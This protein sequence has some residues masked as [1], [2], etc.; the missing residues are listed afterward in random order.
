MTRFLICFLALGG[1]VA[2]AATNIERFNSH[3]FVF[4]AVAPGNPYDA[5][6]AG[7]FSGPGGA[8]MRVP[9]F[10]DGDGR[11]IIRFAPNREGEWQLRTVSSL[12]AL[13]GKT[14]NGIRCEP[15]RS[16]ENHGGLRVDPAHPYHFVYEDGTRYF[17]LGYEA[18]WLWAADMQDPDRR[19]MRK[20]IDQMA[21]RGFNH[22]MVN[23]YAYDTG[24][25]KGR[26]HQWDWGPAPVFPW[27]GTNE[28]PDHSRFNPQYFRIY[29]GMMSAL[30]GKG[31]VAHIMLKVY[32]KQVNWPKPYSRDEERYF[33]Y[34]TARYQ[35]YSN[36]V[37]DFSKEAH[38]ERDLS[39][40]A[41]LIELVRSTDAYHRLLTAHDDDVFYWTPELNRVLDFRTDQQHTFWPEMIAFDRALRRYP[42]LNSEFGYERPVDRFPTYRVEH[43][44]EEQLRR[45]WL[46]YLAGG[47]GVYYYHNTAWDVVKPDPEPPGMK[48]FQ[49]LKETLAALPYWQME[50]HNELAVGGPCLAL[51]GE[52]YAV[53][54]GKDPV[55]I[56]LTGMQAPEKARAEWVDTWT[57]KTEKAALQP[58]PVQR[59]L[60]KPEAFGD[61]P[62]L[63]VIR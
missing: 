33:R 38:N 18:D 4:Q 29:D 25:S 36:V 37:W 27:E 24:W 63:L 56:N 23:L 22:V 41:R 32:N 50:P 2:G 58:S 45:A 60:R 11:W 10:Y 57:G 16:P 31:I 3:D 53:Y 52:A 8:H 7:E 39:L 15:N 28:K 6:L 44:W 54:A 21:S 26:E 43:D 62:A 51:P 12:A 42:V 46:V 19:L 34:V 5:D 30:R 1:A 47:Y 13:D 48:R 59:M 49:L 20:L 61:A 9:G 55:T 17:L 14:E 35:A 40:Q